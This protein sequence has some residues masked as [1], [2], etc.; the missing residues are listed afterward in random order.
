M[1]Y[2]IAII[3]VFVSIDFGL[4]FFIPIPCVHVATVSG[5]VESEVIVVAVVVHAIVVPLFSLL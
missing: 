1:Y 3:M 5:C 4:S 2:V